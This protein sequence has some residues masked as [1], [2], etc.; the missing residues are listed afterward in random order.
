MTQSP[1]FLD[2]GVSRPV[3]DALARN[4][5][6]APFAIQALVMEDALAGHDVGEL[7][8]GLCADGHDLEFVR[9]K[10]SDSMHR[11]T[12]TAIRKTGL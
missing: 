5:I 2:L 11:S 12:R 6:L 1:S 7:E 4:Q 3:V 9:Q 10:I 8:H